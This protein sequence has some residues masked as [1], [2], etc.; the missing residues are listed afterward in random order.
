MPELIF[1]ENLYLA[2]PPLFRLS[3]GSKI[4]YAS[5]IEEKDNILSSNLI[6]KGKVEISRFKGL[7]EMNPI[8]LNKPQWILKKKLIL[9]NSKSADFYSNNELVQK[10][11]GKNPEPRFDYIIENAEFIETKYI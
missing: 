5:S 7:G 9:I 10:L 6:G 3:T 8:Q 2:V 4:I 11:M 1:N